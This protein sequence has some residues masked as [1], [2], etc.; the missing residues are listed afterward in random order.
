[1]LGSIEKGRKLPQLGRRHNVAFFNKMHPLSRL[2]Q[3]N[4][5]EHFIVFCY[6]PLPAWEGSW[7]SVPEVTKSLCVHTLVFTF[8]RGFEGRAALLFFSSPVTNGLWQAPRRS[9]QKLLELVGVRSATCPWGWGQGGRKWFYM[10]ASSEDTPL[11]LAETVTFQ[12]TSKRPWLEEYRS[13][14]R[15][16]DNAWEHKNRSQKPLDT[17]ASSQG[18]QWLPQCSSQSSGRF[19]QWE[20]IFLSAFL[21]IS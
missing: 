1:M 13:S 9:E 18:L 16:E 4:P 6:L 5:T 19:F 17:S 21:C 3:C 7:H 15:E 8:L 12:G 11:S 2:A 20:N 14:D 10:K